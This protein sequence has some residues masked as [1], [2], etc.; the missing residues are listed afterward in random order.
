MIL[1]PLAASPMLFVGLTALLGLLV[2]SFLNVVIYR[3]PIMM[4]NELRAECAALGQSADATESTA[5]ATPKFNL[6]VPPSACPACKS[7][8]TAMQNIPVVSWLTLGRKCAN[9]KAPISARYPAVELA[10]ATLSGFIAWHFGFG[11]AAL[12]A[13]FFTW[14]LIALTMIDFDT[15]FLPDQLTYPLL[16]LG[17]IVSL[18]HPVWAVGAAPI[19]P[20]DSII[21]ATAGYLS[22]WSVYWAFKLITGKEGMG[23]GDFKLF[24]ALG[25]WLGWRMLLPVILFAS[26]V[27]AIFGIAMMIRQS[28]GKETQI[29]FGPFLAVAGWLTMIFG[30][31]VIERYLGMTAYR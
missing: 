21:G 1:E 6:F 14:I 20:D 13:L 9:C 24:A 10:T 18:W 11:A 25:A 22:L 8:I 30:N 27:G 31:A 17:L 23:Y 4:D 5:A 7:P 12:A 2:G 26:A 28:K 15:Q 3:V 29:A 19:L 16:W